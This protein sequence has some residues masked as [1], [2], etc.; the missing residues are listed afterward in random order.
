[1]RLAAI[2]TNA[3]VTARSYCTEFDLKGIS[4]AKPRSP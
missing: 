1:M 2:W 4:M 3:D